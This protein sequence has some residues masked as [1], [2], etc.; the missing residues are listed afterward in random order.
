[1]L[2]RTLGNLSKVCAIDRGVYA[3]IPLSIARIVFE[4]FDIILLFQRQKNLAFLHRERRNALGDDHTSQIC[5]RENRIYCGDGQHNNVIAFLHPAGGI[6]RLFQPAGSILL[7]ALGKG[8]KRLL[9]RGNGNALARPD[10]A[11]CFG[12]KPEKRANFQ[13]RKREHDK[14]IQLVCPEF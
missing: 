14:I 10:I 3:H 13:Q 9:H 5:Q 2:H 7:L 6:R 1:M 12:R 8:R 4:R 11:H